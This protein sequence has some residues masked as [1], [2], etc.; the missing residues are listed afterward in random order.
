MN[1]NDR[2]HLPVLPLRDIVMFPLATLPLMIGRPASLEGCAAALLGDGRMLLVAQKQSSTEIPVAAD[3]Y[4]LGTIAL[5]LRHLP[6]PGGKMQLLVRGERRAAISEILQNQPFL[7]CV[8]QPTG[9][10]A[11]DDPPPSAYAVPFDMRGPLEP[12]AAT[13]ES[14][15]S[16]VAE[17]Q[18]LLEDDALT[19]TERLRRAEEIMRGRI[20]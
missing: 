16:R 8:A 15:E 11:Q 3:L 9:A 17:L 2:T 5:V 10:D 1:P 19:H 20:G 4:Q 13:A 14:A 12:P 7:T 18:E 6:L